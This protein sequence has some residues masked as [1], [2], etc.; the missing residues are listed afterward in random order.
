MSS[1]TPSQYQMQPWR[2]WVIYGVVTF[3][4]G[5]LLYRLVTLQV[6][7]GTDWLDQA[8]EN[9]TT[10]ESIAP[11]RGIIYDRNGFILAGNIASY[12][13]VITPADL[14]DSEADIQN[15]YRQLSALINVPVGGPVTTESLD[16]AKLYGECVPGPPIADMVALGDSLAPYRPVKLAC[17]VDEEVARMV[18]EKAVD[19]P[20]VSVEVERP[21]PG[22][23]NRFV[24]IQCDRVSGAYSSLPGTRISR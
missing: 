24:D 6:I 21:D 17:D 8:V 16:A 15:I 10:T 2:L 3:V 4:L 23:P 13:V 5:S 12:N 11:P 9:Y 22:L 7:Q 20:G 18:R 14:P 19:W 1:T